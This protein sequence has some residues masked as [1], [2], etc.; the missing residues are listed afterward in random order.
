M[1]V[2]VPVRWAAVGGV[3]GPTAFV[4]AWVVGALVIDQ[5]YSSIDDPISRLAA[6]GA[7]TRTVMTAGFV[8]FG[9]A[10]PVYSLALRSMAGRASALAAAATGIATL[11]VAALPLD[12]SPSVDRWHGVAAGVGY[13]TLAAIPL[14]AAPALRRGG[15]SRLARA[16]VAAGATSLAALGL[17]ATALPTGLFQRVGLTVTDVWIVASAVAALRSGATKA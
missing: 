2:P 3:V 13:L 7:D 12:R 14:L 10:V 1:P 11:A 9:L 17:S 6:V 8:A 16:G 4:G 15:R 5:P